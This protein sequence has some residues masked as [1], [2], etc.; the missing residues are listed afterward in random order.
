LPNLADSNMRSQFVKKL[1]ACEKFRNHLDD[2]EQKFADD[3][4]EKFDGRDDD[5]DLGVSPWNPSANQWNTLSE[6]A[7]K[8]S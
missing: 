4:R 5:V 8:V 2:W 7:R 6:I 1:E 3:M